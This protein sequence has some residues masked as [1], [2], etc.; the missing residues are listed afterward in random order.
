MNKLKEESRL[1]KAAVL[2]K[3]PSVVSVS[4]LCDYLNSHQ[5]AKYIRAEVTTSN[6]IAKDLIKQV[7]F[8]FFFT[9]NF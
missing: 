7:F 5:E 1:S 9:F 2:D 6:C 3:R 4:I 8:C